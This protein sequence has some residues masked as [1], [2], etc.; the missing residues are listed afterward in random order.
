MVIETCPSLRLM[1][2]SGLV[3]NL[4]V[5][6]SPI[7]WVATNHPNQ[8]YGI[9]LFILFGIAQKVTKKLVPENNFRAPICFFGPSWVISH[10]V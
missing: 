2:I 6:L 8:K 5:D 10:S 9:F 1:G 3:P 4:L 7:Y